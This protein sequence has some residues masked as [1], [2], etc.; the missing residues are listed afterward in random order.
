MK[1]IVSGRC[2]LMPHHAQPLESIALKA[3]SIALALSRLS[4]S[5]ATLELFICP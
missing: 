4:V 5:V 3:Y 2:F 1:L